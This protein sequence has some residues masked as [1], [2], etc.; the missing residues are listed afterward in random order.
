M[1]IKNP[2]PSLTQ[3]MEFITLLYLLQ[4]GWLITGNIAFTVERLEMART[5]IQL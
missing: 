3:T 4:S 2:T 5:G 1:V